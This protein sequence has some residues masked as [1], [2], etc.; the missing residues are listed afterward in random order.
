MNDIVA[1]IL[2]NPYARYV[3][4]ASDPTYQHVFY[5]PFVDTKS[6]YW[7][8]DMQPNGDVWEIPRK[9]PSDI[10][11][12]VTTHNNVSYWE[13]KL[14]RQHTARAWYATVPSMADPVPNPPFE[15]CWT[16]M[17]G[18]LTPE[19]KHGIRHAI[20]R[21][22]HVRSVMVTCRHQSPEYRWFMDEDC[23]IIAATHVITSL[24]EL[25]QRTI[26][27]TVR[28]VFPFYTM[29]I[30]VHSGPIADD[31][32]TWHTE[33]TD[34]CCVM[35]SLAIAALKQCNWSD[36]AIRARWPAL[37]EMPLVP[38][39]SNRFYV[40]TALDIDAISDALDADGWTPAMTMFAIEQLKLDY[41]HER[42]FLGF[43]HTRHDIPYDVYVA[44]MR[45]M[46]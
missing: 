39:R 28:V 40:A 21:N 34:K 36:D 26:N 5:M 24:R 11:Y 3:H 27:R 22:A 8:A 16:D 45:L 38:V 30:S 29:I 17:H 7:P 32:D 2:K 23:E 35:A 10:K 13:R 14:K 46:Q 37:T 41:I 31:L 12:V 20:A 43:L 18:T 44:M 4:S 1:Q 25:I 19:V 9:K 33:S 42:K 6:P 15:P